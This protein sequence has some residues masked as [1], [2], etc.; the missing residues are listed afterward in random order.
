MRRLRSFEENSVE[1]LEIEEE[2]GRILEIEG[3]DLA[4]QPLQQPFPSLKALFQNK[5]LLTIIGKGPNANIRAFYYL[6]LCHIRNVH[7]KQLL[8]EHKKQTLNQIDQE[9]DDFRHERRVSFNCKGTLF[10]NGPEYENF[11]LHKLKMYAFSKSTELLLINNSPFEKSP[12]FQVEGKALSSL[13]IK[14]LLS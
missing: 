4:Q 5:T 2:F 1:N 10:L 9:E 6:L 3:L 7:L 8:N 13:Q 11:A 12:T 14:K